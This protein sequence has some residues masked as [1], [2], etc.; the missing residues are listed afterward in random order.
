MTKIKSKGNI[1]ASD[2]RYSELADDIAI[3]RRTLEE[4]AEGLKRIA[5]SL[6][7]SF[8]AA[9]DAM[10]AAVGRVVVSGIGKSG[11]IGRKIA[12]TLASTGKPSQ[13]VNAAEAS[14]GDLGM[15][16]RDDVL[17][18][19][20]NSGNTPELAALIDFSCKLNISLIAITGGKNSLLAKAAN[21]ALILPQLTEAC[22][23][24]LAPT[25]TTTGML[26]LGDALAVALM[27]REGFSSKGFNAL[28][29]GGQL[30]RQFMQVK[31]IM[32]SGASIPLVMK[33]DLMS[34]ALL[35]MTTKS[36]GCVGVIDKNQSLAGIIT[37]G[38]LRRN[39]DE[40]LLSRFACDVMTAG[41]Q[42]IPLDMLGAQALSL[43]NELK[44]TAFFIVE[45]DNRPVG[46]IHIHDL[47]RAG[48]G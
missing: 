19:L 3:G 31:E 8:V 5:D 6:D 29:P 4:E 38:D 12:A 25:T 30:G 9:L 13:Y 7:S 35:E 10:Q 34:K 15:I 43:M 36:F 2:L 21:I 47:I 42:T 17:V 23:L 40:Q 32:H 1:N 20:S 39:M 26:A 24:G 28:H 44:I 48:L 41:S 18:V 16:T 22:P 45:N 33:K 27:Q 46:I 11:N 14:H 37:D